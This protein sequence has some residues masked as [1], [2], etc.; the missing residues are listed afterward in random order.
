ME[1]PAYFVHAWNAQSGVVTHTAYI[2]DFPGPFPF[3]TGSA[4]AK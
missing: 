4:A 2:G 1:P 3:E